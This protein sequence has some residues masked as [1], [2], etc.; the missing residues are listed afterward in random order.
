MT[1]RPSDNIT[2]EDVARMFVADGITILQVQDAHEWGQLALERLAVGMDAARRTEAMAA[3]ISAHQN[4]SWDKQ[5]HPM[6]IEPRWWYPPSGGTGL[7]PM[8]AIVQQ[9]RLHLPPVVHSME[10]QV[11]TSVGVPAEALARMP[12]A[13]VATPVLM[14]ASQAVQPPEGHM[15]AQVA[16]D[17]GVTGW[18]GVAIVYRPRKTRKPRKSRAARRRVDEEAEDQSSSPDPELEKEGEMALPYWQPLPVGDDG[19]ALTGSV[20]KDIVME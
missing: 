12:A 17:D 6:P 18:T 8:P 7:A 10:G 14:A 2:V 1:A 13:P 11:R 19:Q 15:R 9:Q 16:P 3:Q 5:D 20:P 4:S